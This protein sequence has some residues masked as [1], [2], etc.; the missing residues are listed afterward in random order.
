MLAHG[1]QVAAN[2]AKGAGSLLAAEGA[3]DFLLDLDYAQIAL[4]LMVGERHRQI[5]QE[6]QH[7]FDSAEQC[8]KQ[9][10]R[11]TR[12]FAAR[13]DGF[14]V[15]LRGSQGQ[16][17]GKPLPEHLKIL[18]HEGIS[19][20]LQNGFGSLYQGLTVKGSSAHLDGNGK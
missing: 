10:F 7:L 16:M 18:E 9:I 8:I 14:G 6:R 11:G 5:T 3:G 17:P 15:R 4:G 19:L 12:P 20:G 2:G 13:P 1:G